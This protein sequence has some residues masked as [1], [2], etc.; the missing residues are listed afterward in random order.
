MQQVRFARQGSRCFEPLL[1][2]AVITSLV[3]VLSN[4]A[5]GEV[6]TGSHAAAYPALNVAAHWIATGFEVAGISSI[7]LVALG[8]SV[9][10]ARALVVA[11]NWMATIPDFRA[12]LGRGVLLGLELLVAADI[13][14]TVAIAPTFDSLGVLAVVILIRTFLSISLGVEIEGH[15]PWRRREIEKNVGG[16]PPA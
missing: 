12:D 5:W 11:P 15:W 16:S 4:P 6:S 14:G 2:T 7:L 10:F 1:R 3:I 8:A 13:V 9:R